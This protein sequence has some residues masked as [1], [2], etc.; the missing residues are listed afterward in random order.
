MESKCAFR[1]FGSDTPC[2]STKALTGHALG[3]AGAI[4]AGFMWIALSHERG[5]TIPLPPHVWDKEADPSLPSLRFAKEGE[6][7][8]PIQGRFT[9]ISNSFAFGGSNAS[10]VLSSRIKE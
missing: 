10:I 8:A 4:E 3:A 1:I 2:S 6:R 5:G 9:M 7:A